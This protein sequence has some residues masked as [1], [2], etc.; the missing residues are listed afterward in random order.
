MP[1]RTGTSQVTWSPSTSSRA[2]APALFAARTKLPRGRT[3]G[4]AGGPA[5]PDRL[6]ARGQQGAAP[7]AS[8]SGGR[9]AGEAGAARAAAAAAVV[10][11]CRA[12]AWAAVLEGLHLFLPASPLAPAVRLLQARAR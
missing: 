8:P 3:P 5:G 9:A 2:R 1:A 12:G 11:A 4:P 6:S 10:A 7:G